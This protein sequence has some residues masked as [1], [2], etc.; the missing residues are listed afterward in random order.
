MGDNTFWIKEGLMAKTV[1]GWA[2]THRVIKGEEA[3]L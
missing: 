3:W 1:T 2:R